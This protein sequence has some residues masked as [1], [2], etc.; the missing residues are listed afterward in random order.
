MH[1]PVQESP[2]QDVGE[3]PSD[4]PSGEE[5][6][7]RF[8]ALVP[9]PSSLEDEQQGEQEG[10]EEIEN[11]PVQSR[12]P[13]DAGCRPRQSRNGGAAVVQHSGV[14][15]HRHFA[16]ELWSLTFGPNS[17]HLG[18]GLPPEGAAVTGNIMQG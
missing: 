13:K 8:E 12:Q 18:S 14:P 7:P 1:H 6:P 3:K 16:D 2:E 17:C 11:E 9:P 10:R 15:P 4:Q 5:Q